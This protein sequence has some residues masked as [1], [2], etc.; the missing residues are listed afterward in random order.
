MPGNLHGLHR[1]RLAQLGD[2]LPPESVKSKTRIIDA[3]S[4]RRRAQEMLIDVPVIP[5]LAILCS[6]GEHERFGIAFQPATEVVSQIAHRNITDR[7]LVL[8]NVK[9]SAIKALAN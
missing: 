8:G 6:H 1:V 7:S 9:V 2:G 5:A 3:E 4:L